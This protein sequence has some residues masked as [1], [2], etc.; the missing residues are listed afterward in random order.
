MKQDWSTTPVMINH[1]VNSQPRTVV[2]YTH[3]GITGPRVERNTRTG[4]VEL[5]GKASNAAFNRLLQV[6]E[7]DHFGT[8]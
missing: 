3:L 5:C 6:S 7:Y 4:T 8:V 1:C 2:Y